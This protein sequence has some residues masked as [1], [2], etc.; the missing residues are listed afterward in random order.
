MSDLTKARLEGCGWAI[1]AGMA[2][3]GLVYN[4]SGMLDWKALVLGGLGGLFLYVRNNVKIQ[5]PTPVICPKCGTA[6]P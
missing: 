5:A 3:V 2:T 4:A 1:L 6:I